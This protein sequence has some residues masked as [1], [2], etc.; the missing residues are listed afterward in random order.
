MDDVAGGDGVGGVDFSDQEKAKAWLKIQSISVRCAI[1]S[2]AAL[3]VCPT[4]CEL[5]DHGLSHTALVVLRAILTSAVSSSRNA[6]NS[7]WIG[8]S[9][10]SSAYAAA[11]SA[12]RATN[13][14]SFPAASA[15]AAARAAALA[16]SW[17]PADLSSRSNKMA[18]NAIS[19]SISRSADRITSATIDS[20]YPD[21]ADHRRPLWLTD[22]IPDSVLT[23]HMGFLRFLRKNPNTWRFWHNWY[24]GMWEGRFN[25]WDLAIEVAKIPDA[26]WEEGA[27]AVAVEI[28]QIK[29]RR[30]ADALPQAERIEFNSVDKTFTAIPVKLAKAELIGA[31]LQ[32]VEDSLEDVMASP[33]TGLSEA[34]REVKVIHRTLQKYGNNPQQIEMGFVSAHAGLTRQIFVGDLPPS[35][36]NL[37]L[38]TA[39]EEGAVAIRATHPDVAEN[40]AILTKRKF[41]ELSQEQKDQLTEALPVLKAISDDDLAD[42]WDNDIPELVNTSMGPLPEGAPPLLGADEATRIFSRAAKI[43]ILL[44]TGSIIH[45]IDQSAT[46]KGARI[47][48]T[49]GGLVS[50]GLALLVL[51]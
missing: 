28:E 51:I 12:A 36:E 40:R 13:S 35:E 14:S 41:A 2:R 34:S 15:I 7:D 30:L 20:D 24:L 33:S 45:Q 44:R 27:E 25:D 17:L 11:I 19:R 31:T 10:S 9:A 50:L 4:I 39:L 48:L 1:S 32:Q 42:D 8:K 49:V 38:Q 18:L 26:I 22:Q 5:P 37:A 23:Y 29:A 46:Y 3:R 21:I 43:S 47:V 6:I 16:V